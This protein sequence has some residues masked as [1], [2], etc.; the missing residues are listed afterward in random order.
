MRRAWGASIP[1]TPT[2][3]AVSLVLARADAP[4]LT[5]SSVLFDGYRVLEVVLRGRLVVDN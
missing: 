5:V 2:T 1:L 3:V 4:A